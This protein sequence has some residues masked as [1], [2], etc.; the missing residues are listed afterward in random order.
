M[1]LVG[2]VA[3]VL[4]AFAQETG[5]S[6]PLTGF[7]VVDASFLP[8]NQVV[9]AT[10]TDGA[11]VELPDPEGGE[12]AI[13]ADVDAGASIGSVSLELTGAKT[14]G[15]K[16]DNKVPYSLYGDRGK[17]DLLGQD[18]PVGN[19]TISATAYS[20]RDL[21]GDEL[22]TLEM[23]FI[24]AQADLP[25]EFDYASYDFTISEDAAVATTVG[26]V[27]ATDP[28]ADTLAYAITAGN[29]DGKFAINGA[30]GAVKVAAALD[31]ESTAS[32]ALTVQADDGNGG[33]ADMAVNVTVTACTASEGPPVPTAVTV[34]G[35]PIVVTSTTD[36]Y[37]V[38]YVSH[39][40]AEGNTIEWP[41]AVIV[42]EDGTT[43]LSVNMGTLPAERYRVEKYQ[44]SEPADVDGDCI[45]DITELGNLGEMSPVNPTPAVDLEHGTVAIPDESTFDAVSYDFPSS[46][47]QIVKFLATGMD[48][49]RPSLY[50]M[51]INSG[52]TPF[53]QQR[54]HHFQFLRAIGLDNLSFY[55]GHSA[56]GEI[57]YDPDLIGPDGSRGTYYFRVETFQYTSA[58][59]LLQAYTLLAANLPLVDDNLALHIRNYLLPYMESV[60]PLLKA[61]GVPLLLDDD[62]NFR[63]EAK[64]RALNE[65]VGY[66][67]L[68]LLDGDERPHPR[69]I[70]IYEVLPNELPPVAG[71]ISTVPQTLLSHVNLR[72]GQNGIPNAYIRDVL[73]RSG[74][75][76]LVDE[77]VRFE[78]TEA[79]YSIRVATPAEVEAHYASSRP[80]FPRI[81]LRDLSVTSITP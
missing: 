27:S 46:S 15:P 31:H 79:R 77:Y 63:G 4:P 5:S 17:E 45:D 26:I 29:G 57:I 65:G 50:F 59:I 12:Y 11:T 16:T 32:Y 75:A 24:V 18:L 44:V 69:D 81:P 2:A 22:G 20:G 30:S 80:F 76:D 56:D 38:V 13:R 36:D 42:G 41:V 3:N 9:L 62:I 1:G 6:G 47:R 10:V 58:E 64:F 71:I 53:G 8:S 35:V 61:S 40:T 39:E 78:V 49:D 67:R 72:A 74:V 14:V 21:S 54:L 23:S 28:N 60:V 33:T 68:R 52:Q 51:N 19:Y 37:F 55:R 25:P 73:D 48:T 70:A 34:D 66:G 43:T 7:T